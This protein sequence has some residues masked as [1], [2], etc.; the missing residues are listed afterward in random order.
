MNLA[1][2]K[3]LG[4]PSTVRPGK[5]PRIGLRGI[6]PIGARHRSGSSNAIT[7]RGHGRERPAQQ[8]MPSPPGQALRRQPNGAFQ[9]T[10]NRLLASASPYG[11]P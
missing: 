6:T 9:G 4:N 8:T 3:I 11:R 5:W 2:I 1:M 7:E 10:L